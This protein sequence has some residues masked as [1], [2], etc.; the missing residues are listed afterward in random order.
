MNEHTLVAE[1][2]KLFSIVKWLAI[3][4]P[5]LRHLEQTLSTTMHAEQPADRPDRYAALLSRPRTEAAQALVSQV[6]GEFAAWQYQTGK[7]VRKFRVKSGETYHDAIERFVGDLL[8][9]RGNSESSGRIYHAMGA[10]TF[11]DVPVNYDVFKGMLTGLV[12]LGLVGFDKGRIVY[13]KAGERTVLDR[14]ATAF[15]ATDRL[16][17]LA[18]HFGAHMENIRDHFKPEPPHNPLVLRGPG[19]RSGRKKI[20]GPIIKYKHDK[21]TRKLEADIKELNTFLAGCEIT[22]GEHEGYTRNFNNASWRKGGR[23]Y[24]I[25]GGYQQMSPPEK[26]LEMTINGEAVAEIDIKASHLTIYHAKLKAPLSRDSDPYERL[27]PD[28]RTIAKLWTVASFGN[29]APATKWPPE[30]AKDYKKD[31]GK[32][33]AKVAKARA[34]KAMMLEAFPALRK[35]EQFRGKDI[36]GGLQYIEA[37]AVFNTMLILMREHGIPSLS[38]HDGIIVPQSSVRPKTY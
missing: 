23:L 26:C 37:E 2:T 10:T 15:W 35:L 19:E 8:R 4:P 20:K 21:H 6:F 9:A 3:T 1:R 16:V 13:R 28:N 31:T 17:K 27:G 12:G 11:D 18:E 22:G 30:M 5:P 25:G 38:M 33:L 14:R 29:S 32:D 7:C 34:I 24:S 36:W